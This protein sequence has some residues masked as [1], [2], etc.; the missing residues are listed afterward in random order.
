MME[1]LSSSETS[2]LTRAARRNIPEDAILCSHSC[3]NLKSY[4]ILV[5]FYCRTEVMLNIFRSLICM[6]NSSEVISICGVQRIHKYCHMQIKC[7]HSNNGRLQR[8]FLHSVTYS[9]LPQ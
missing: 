3:E 9:I 8:F 6:Y 7:S 2:V 4:I 5:S 1:A